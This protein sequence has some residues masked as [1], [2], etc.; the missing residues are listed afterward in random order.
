[1]TEELERDVAKVMVAILA[2]VAAAFFL[3]GLAI[4]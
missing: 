2:C 3:L 1:M 4:G